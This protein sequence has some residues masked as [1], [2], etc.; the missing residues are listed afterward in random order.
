V[1]RSSFVFTGDREGEGG[2][3]ERGDERER[4]K[5]NMFEYVSDL[6]RT[7]RSYQHT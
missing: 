4:E 6:A 7:N 3:L 2:E 1:I 5:G